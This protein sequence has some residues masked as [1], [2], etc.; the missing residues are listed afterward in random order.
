[1]KIHR[2][3]EEENVNENSCRGLKNMTYKWMMLTLSCIYKESIV[4][5][6]NLESIIP[7]LFLKSISEWS[8]FFK[9]VPLLS[10]GK[11]FNSNYDIPGC[12]KKNEYTGLAQYGDD[13]M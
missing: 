9:A 3:L 7:F 2:Y 5:S 11:S 8:W 13:N 10:P 1:M 4:T 12:G 6:L